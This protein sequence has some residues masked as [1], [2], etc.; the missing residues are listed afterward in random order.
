ML[1]RPKLYEELKNTGIQH[2]Q[3]WYN[4]ITNPSEAEKQ[5]DWFKYTVFERIN[6]TDEYVDFSF[7]GRSFR[8]MYEVQMNE[9]RGLL[10]LYERTYNKL[11]N[12]EQPIWELYHIEKMDLVYFIGSPMSFISKEAGYGYT[13]PGIGKEVTISIPEMKRLYV[14]SLERFQNT[15]PK[16]DGIS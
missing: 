6:L 5:E 7:Y 12:E 4:Y 11:N 2:L 13:I 3:T 15:L 1:N 9:E 14:L 10:K 8:L 16:R